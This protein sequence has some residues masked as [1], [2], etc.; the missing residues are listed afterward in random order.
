M[1]GGMSGLEGGMT[2]EKY[3]WREVCLEGGMTR[4][5]YDWREV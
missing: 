2:R 1:E 3:D 5:R 4:G